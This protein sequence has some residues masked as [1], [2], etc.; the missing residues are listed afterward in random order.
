[1]RTRAQLLS[2]YRRCPPESYPATSLLLDSSLRLFDSFEHAQLKVD[3]CLQSKQRS[4]T[5][6]SS[7]AIG[8]FLLL[9]CFPALLGTLLF[10]PAYQ[11]VR[12]L[13]FRVAGQ[14][15]DIVATVK[16]ISGAL[17]VVFTLLFVTSASYWAL[18]AIGILALPMALVSA[19]AALR[20]FEFIAL[21]SRRMQYKR[22]LNKGNDN[23]ISLQQERLN[24]AHQVRAWLQADLEHETR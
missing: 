11:L 5:Q 22:L 6:Q 12:Y 21:I 19:W 2:C 24:L 13:A 7:L 23:F 9:L 3:A 17:F 10:F 1:M 15:L 4:L 16:L 20:F 18:G 14:E 8:L